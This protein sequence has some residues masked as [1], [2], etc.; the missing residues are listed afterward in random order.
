MCLSVAMAH[1]ANVLAKGEHAGFQWIVT[2]NGSAHRCGYVRVEPGHPWYG[3]EWTEIDCECHGDVTFTEHDRPC[4]LGE[5]DD[6]Y[7]IGFDCMHF[8]DLPDPLLSSDRGHRHVPFGDPFAA[9]RTQEYVEQNCRSL[10]EQ[11]AKA[12]EAP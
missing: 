4:A 6:G 5:K 9:I 3:K 10:C 1:P 8:R 7:W 2:N 11:A 12:Q